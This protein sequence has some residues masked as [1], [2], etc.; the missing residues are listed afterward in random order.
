VGAAE[1]IEGNE[2]TKSRAYSPAVITG[3]GRIVWVAGMGATGDSDRKADQRFRG[4]A[5]KDRVAMP[6]RLTSSPN[7]ATATMVSFNGGSRATA[8]RI[9]GRSISRLAQLASASGAGRMTTVNAL[10][11]GER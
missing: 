9:A 4:E 11:A 6:R 5:N 7:R 3:G 1:F 2:R 10:L 8:P